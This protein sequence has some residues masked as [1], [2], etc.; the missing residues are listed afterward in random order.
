MASVQG[1]A[2]GQVRSLIVLDRLGGGDPL[3]GS[4]LV[5]RNP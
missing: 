3:R 5:D 2:A 4:L 1:V